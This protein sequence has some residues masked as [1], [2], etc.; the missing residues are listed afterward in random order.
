MIKKYLTICLLALLMLPSST[1]YAEYDRA[2][3]KGFGDFLRA[4]IDLENF[5]VYWA[6]IFSKNMCQLTD[7]M[8]L[9]EELDDLQDSIRD[10]YYSCDYQTVGQL[11]EEY[12][13]TKAEMYFVRN[14]LKSETDAMT[15]TEIAELYENLNTDPLKEEMYDKYVLNKGWFVDEDFYSMFEDFLT[16]YE[17]NIYTYFYCSDVNWKAIGDKWKEWNE[18]AQI[19]ADRQIEKESARSEEQGADEDP[20]G[21]KSSPLGRV[22]EFFTKHLDVEIS[23]V[24]NVSQYLDQE[25]ESSTSSDEGETASSVA[26]QSLVSLFDNYTSELSRYGSDIEEAELIAKYKFL[27]GDGGSEISKSLEQKLDTLNYFVNESATIYLPD[28]KKASHRIAKRQ[29]N[30]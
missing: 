29:C 20:A 7:I 18:I 5:S 26:G 13:K 8:Q 27:Y 17:D 12:Y 14:I 19:F 9:E 3:G 6:D 21:A 22:G 16:Q 30:D 24:D 15:S 2:C 25:F 23:A 28:I 10:R 4:S 11:T 1:A